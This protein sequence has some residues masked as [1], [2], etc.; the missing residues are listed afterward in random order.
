MGTQVPT[1][2]RENEDP[3]VKIGIPDP[4]Y[5]WLFSQE[6]EDPLYGRPSIISLLPIWASLYRSYYG[7]EQSTTVKE[8]PIKALAT[9][10]YQLNILTAYKTDLSIHLCSL[11]K[12]FSER[13]VLAI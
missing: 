2:Y 3:L 6:Y 5:G 9:S 7:I 13:K 10:K 8:V 12:S 11:V 1:L 4:L